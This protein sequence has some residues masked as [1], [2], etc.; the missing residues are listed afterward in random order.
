MNATIK[1]TNCGQ[2]IELSQALLHQ[3]EEQVKAKARQAVS[4]EL[5]DRENQIAELREQNKALTQQLLDLNRSIRELKNREEKTTLEYEKRLNEAIE[6]NREELLRE[7]GEKYKLREMEYEKKLADMSRA[8]EEA[9]VKAR[10][11]SQQ[12]QGEVLELNIEEKLR[13]AFVYD[14]ISPVGKGSHG[15]DIIQTVKNQTGKTAGIILWET[16]RAKWTPSWLAKL[17]EDGR[18]AGA[19]IVVLVSE[20]VPGEIGTFALREGVV[21]T[22]YPYVL[23]LAELLRR[24]VMQVAQARSTAA[25]KDE[26]LEFLYQYLSSDSFRHHF[27]A[28]AE[29]IRGMEEDL[30]TERRSMERVWKK[31]E[32]QIRRSLRA[33]ASLYGELQGIMGSALP[34][35]RTFSLPEPDEKE[36]PQETIL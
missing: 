21:V 24:S 27:E 28:Y 4:V 3:V 18:N 34:E 10:Q 36:P 9:R 2:E 20:N 32:M 19:T 1:C 6:R 14:D 22:T 31:R 16:K 17:R 13:T 29:T 5:K 26:K 15:A 35:I 11:G 25:N 23:P 7:Q 30:A 8:L 33:I 12:L